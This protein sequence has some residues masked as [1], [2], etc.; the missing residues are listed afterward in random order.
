MVQYKDEEN[1]LEMG[2]TA[3]EALVPSLRQIIPP[4]KQKSLSWSNITYTVQMG[5][6]KKQV[7]K[8]ILN[9]I[10]G[11]LASSHFLAIM[12]PTGS[13]KT[14]LLNV[15]AGRVGYN[16][17]SLL[18]GSISIN[19]QPK[20]DR[21]FRR[22]SAYVT[23]DDI[24]YTHLT[25][26][27]TL[28]MAAN[29]SLPKSTPVAEKEDF[30]LSIIKELGLMKAT[31]TIIGDEHARGVSGGERKRVNIGVE[32]ISDPT[33]LF[34]DEPTSGLD[35]FQAQS[36]ME[37][38]K[39]MAEH[40]R[41]IIS[42]IHQ[43]RSSIFAMFDFLL[44]LSE[45][46]VVY[47]GVAKDAVAYFNQCGFECPALYNPADYFLDVISPDYRSLEAEKNSKSTIEILTSRWLE[48][49]PRAEQF[50]PPIEILKY[51]KNNQPITEDS[52]NEGLGYKSS[53][54][55][56]FLMI[57]KRSFK[58]AARNKFAIIVKYLLSA[59]FGLILGAIYSNVHH[60]QKSIQDRIGIL[61]FV[62]INQ[63]FGAMFPVLSLFPKE[64]KIVS[65][66]RASKSYHISAYYIAKAIAE[67][68]FNFL[69][70]LLFGVLVYWIVGLHPTAVHFFRFILIIELETFLSIA[71]GMIISA[72]AKT[73]ELAQVLGPPVLVVLILFGGFYI[74]LTSIPIGARWVT[75]LSLFRWSFE[76]LL[77]NEF[78]GET[79]E[80]N[81]SD[82]GG[83]CITDGSTVLKNLSFGSA[84]YPQSILGLCMLLIGSNLIAYLFLRFKKTKYQ[85]LI[86]HN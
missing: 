65:R 67:V 12:G 44:L 2:H 54:F 35:S 59:F 37:S 62:T 16:K 11:T 76:G 31:D 20:V 23:Q 64:Y 73:E 70:P 49:S 18:T 43:P 58:Q 81:S 4:E 79:F 13:G 69:G 17:K 40:G 85:P 66:E 38:M 55:D 5:K 1:Q 30:V 14:S 10:S 22:I 50:K 86:S 74:N 71:I 26:K 63:A 24:L 83:S 28:I 48:N 51:A 53:W 36:V 52:L 32:L 75:D 82:D 42:S 9:N 21:L 34:L 45:G 15:L 19:G 6:G 80:C 60:T 57:Y 3:N 33:I 68:P 78:I 56:Q 41:T 61:F 77:V 46:K 8:I 39:T 27:E 29:F 7:E 47:H 84:T 72:V 25:V